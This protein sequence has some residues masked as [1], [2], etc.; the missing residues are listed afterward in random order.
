M[1]VTGRNSSRNNSSSSNS[2]GASSSTSHSVIA[3]APVGFSTGTTAAEG[4]ELF[5]RAAAVTS[6]SASTATDPFAFSC[7][8]GDESED[9]NA[10]AAGPSTTPRSS[11]RHTSNNNSG[12][13]V[14]RTRPS[15]LND[16]PL[17]ESRSVAPISSA[18]SSARDAVPPSTHPSSS[19]AI[20]SVK[21]SPLWAVVTRV[22]AWQ[23]G[24]N[25][26]M[27]C[28]WP[29]VREHIA[30]RSGARKKSANTT[31][32]AAS[33]KRD[34]GGGSGGSG[35]AVRTHAA[36]ASR[37]SV[38]DDDD[39]E[40]E[41]VE[42]QH[43]SASLSSSS[44][45]SAAAAAAA[46]VSTASSSPS[47]SWNDI[48][49]PPSAPV[50]PARASVQQSA[51][52]SSA[53]TASADVRT[54]A[55]GGGS[56][57]SGSAAAASAAA[58]SS[59]SS[60]TTP[61]PPST[62]KGRG[63]HERKRLRTW[64]YDLAHPADAAAASAR[65]DAAMESLF[66]FP[67]CVLPFA[68][69]RGTTLTAALESGA[70]LTPIRLNTP[71]RRYIARRLFDLTAHRLGWSTA[72]A[73][74]VSVFGRT[75]FAA[76]APLDSPPG[77]VSSGSIGSS[78]V[79]AIANHAREL[80]L[81]STYAPLLVQPIW[82]KA[83]A[84]VKTWDTHRM[85]T[86]VRTAIHTLRSGVGPNP[87]SRPSW[88][89]ALPPASL[90]SSEIRA[91]EALLHVIRAAADGGTPAPKL[92]ANN[93]SATVTAAVT[94]AA[95]AAVPFPL[96]TLPAPGRNS[97]GATVDITSSTLTA[98]A[99]PPAQLRRGTATTASSPAPAAAAAAV[100]SSAASA[101]GVLL[102]TSTVT[103]PLPSSSSA[104]RPSLQLTGSVIG[105]GAVVAPSQQRRRLRESIVSAA[106]A[107]PLA[108]TRAAVLEWLRALV[109]AYCVPVSA[110]PMYE[111]LSFS[112]TGTLRRVF[113]PSHRSAALGAL[114]SPH[115]YIACDCC[116]KPPPG[117]DALDVV[118]PTMPGAVIL[119]KL[120]E[121]VVEE[122]GSGASGRIV[123]VA[124][125]WAE[126]VDLHGAQLAAAEE[127]DA[128]DA[129]ATASM[130][131]GSG[132]GSDDDED[133]DEEEEEAKAVSASPKKKR[134]RPSFAS[135]AAAAA[136]KDDDEEEE[137]EEA[138]GRATP[139]KRGRPSFASLAA[140][141]A[142]EKEEEQEVVPKKRGR[143]SF[144]SLAAAA[145]AAAQQG[146]GR[147]SSTAA[148]VHTGIK[149]KF[150]RA[151]SEL[152]ATGL[153]RPLV[154]GGA[155][156]LELCVSNVTKW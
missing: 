112:G 125:V 82:D 84:V 58:S 30:K 123:G 85:E 8:S 14:K 48:P 39:S 93:S 29:S 137:E 110:L 138:A 141:A 79:C 45:S 76:T 155:D 5:S 104:P 117:S 46:F 51:A 57:L 147:S 128:E 47:A 133:A 15:L 81:Q 140:A 156:A 143:P 149:A 53:A 17:S 154:R 150:L 90:F 118:L 59:S 111:A 56:P 64:A 54:T 97:R 124:E 33:A 16:S 4:K 108:A 28:A 126:F 42:A 19:S 127:E 27:L 95:A 101:A 106:S 152:R 67:L 6:R 100:A 80:H 87:R 88:A 62:G 10:A 22:V 31:S 119:Y 26:A 41:E 136:A 1:L 98:M 102:G 144:A 11:A 77:A 24:E 40:S 13:S 116:P 52:H 139:K 142:E 91:G 12:E 61:L 89:S 114:S 21:E 107:H 109:G 73:V 55:P 146:P 38:Y 86:F 36:S 25:V 70:L 43:S 96:M 49:L 72:A 130:R 115:E 113:A 63:F 105:M 129:A 151:Y 135:L 153:V 122:N 9:G 37:V 103:F 145:A 94:A 120:L 83:E 2:S 23:P 50:T 69:V 7:D 34:G 121:R 134:G 75:L 74:L 35:G 148:A 68:G 131:G 132:G 66:G 20:P 92:R 18:A 71:E 3:P 60:T 65:D 78:C 44:S 99:P 32:A